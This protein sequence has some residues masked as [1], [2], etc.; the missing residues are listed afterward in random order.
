MLKGIIIFFVIVC[1]INVIFVFSACVSAG[2][3][4]RREEEEMSKRGHELQN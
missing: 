3:E 4:S 1:V 2:R